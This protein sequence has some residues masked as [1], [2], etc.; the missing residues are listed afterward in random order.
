VRLDDRTGSMAEKRLSDSGPCVPVFTALACMAAA[1][2][3]STRRAPRAL[4]DT[5]QNPLA[6]LLEGARYRPSPYSLC[7]VDRVPCAR[8]MG[9]NAE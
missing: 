2:E 3:F 6:P 7:P 5:R 9:S 8:R 1:S 4:I